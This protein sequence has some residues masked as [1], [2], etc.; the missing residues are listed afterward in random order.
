LS[1]TNRRSSPTVSARPFRNGAA[2]TPSSSGGG[3]GDPLTRLNVAFAST[4]SFCASIKKPA[5]KISGN[6]LSAPSASRSVFSASAIRRCASSHSLRCTAR[7]AFAQNRIVVLEPANAAS[8]PAVFASR[9]F[10]QNSWI[11]PRSGIGHILVCATMRAG[12]HE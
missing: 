12:D 11:A 8:R 7:M 3:I 2:A 1:S 5:K 9:R 4:Y 6:G 10:R